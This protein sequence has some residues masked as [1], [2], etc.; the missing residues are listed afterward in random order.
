MSPPPKYLD[1]GFQKYN[2]HTKTVC[3]VF[4]HM[5]KETPTHFM[6]KSDL[7]GTKTSDWKI[8]K[9]YTSEEIHALPDVRQLMTLPFAE[10][11]A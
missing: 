6:K 8:Y 4:K 9:Y 3:N 1:L 10:L 5:G 2:E 7:I 11:D